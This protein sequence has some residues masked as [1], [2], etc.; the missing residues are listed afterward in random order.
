MERVSI[1]DLSDDT[2]ADIC[3]R[4]SAADLSSAARTCR[5]RHSVEKDHR[6]F[7]W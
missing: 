3:Q 6:E 4:L 7:V 1:H 2:L 5:R